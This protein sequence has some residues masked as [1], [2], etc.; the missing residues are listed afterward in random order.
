MRL[1]APVMQLAIAVNARAMPV[2]KRAI[3]MKKLVIQM[4]AVACGIAV[5]VLLL[6]CSPAQEDPSSEPAVSKEDGRLTIYT[7]NY[8]LEYLAERIGGEFV[9]AVFPAPPGIDPAYWSP[10]LEQVAAYQAADLIFR[11]GAG[12][13]VWVDRASFLRRQLIDTSTGFRDRLIPLDEALVHTH[14]PDGDHSHSGTAFTTWLD[15]TL[16]LEHAR[17]IT[18]ALVALR[19]DQEEVFEQ[20]LHALEDDLARL[21]QR[22]EQVAQRLG[23]SPLVFSHPVYAYLERRYRLNGRSL[24]WEPNQVPDA[25]MW[26]EFASLLEVHPAQLMLWEGLPE[27]ETQQRLAALGVAIAIYA[28]SAQPPDTGD[29]L[30]AMQSN[31]AALETYLAER[32]P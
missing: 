17:V 19:P 27:T 25:E 4:S 14:G 16:A 29:W 9:T 18:G 13:A 7:V 11:N 32:S 24:H 12:Y 31:V 28:P 20:N 21:D 30:T 10:E 5:A 2:K 26:Q 8:P 22:L 1:T 23:E 3:R 15:P 6:A